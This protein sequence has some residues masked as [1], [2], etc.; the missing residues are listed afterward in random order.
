MSANAII[1]LNNYIALVSMVESFEV[2]F[3]VES[4]VRRR[5]A[6]LDLGKMSNGRQYSI[7][8]CAFSYT[9]LLIC[10]KFLIRA[11][12]RRCPF[13]HNGLARPLALHRHQ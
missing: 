4:V 7:F 11:S 2:F 1:V 10:R 5:S 3:E 9:C 8:R 6:K 12:R 13:V